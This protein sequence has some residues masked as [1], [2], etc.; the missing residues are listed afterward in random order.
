MVVQV[1]KMFCTH[2]SLL[3]SVRQANVVYA[4]HCPILHVCVSASAISPVS[5]K[6]AVGAPGNKDDLV[7]FA[8]QKSQRLRSSHYRGGGVQSSSSAF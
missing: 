4:F 2:L 7:S 5:V 3:P 8:G 6:P 1:S